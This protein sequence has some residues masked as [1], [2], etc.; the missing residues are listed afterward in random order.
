DRWSCRRRADLGP[1]RLAR[2][3][4][5]HARARLHGDR[6]EGAP[7]PA[8]GVDA[9]RRP[10]RLLRHPRGRLRRLHPPGFGHVRGPRADLAGQARQSRSLPVAL[11]L[12]AR[13]RPR[14]GA[15]G[16]RRGGQGPPRARPQ[17]AGRAL[18]ARVPGPV[19]GGLRARRRGAVDRDAR[20]R[21][22]G[23]M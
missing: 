21:R 16:A 12:G 13:G 17:V 10:D 3:R 8:G 9:A 18:E 23:G 11:S 6:H 7:P 4:R 20:T 14:G 5:R 19:A 15:V 2:E 1:D 22:V